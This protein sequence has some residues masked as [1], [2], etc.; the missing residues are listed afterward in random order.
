MQRSGS[1]A[2]V[3]VNE[4]DL[5]Q[6]AVA[7]STSIGVIVGRALRGE[8][9]GTT[10]IT[11]EKKQ[12]SQFGKP[13]AK[14]DYAIHSA[15][16]FMRHA[17]QLYFT[18]IAPESK[19]AG[20]TVK[21]G[22]VGGTGR[23]YNGSRSL[24]EGLEDPSVFD[25]AAEDLF[26]IVGS[27]QGKWAEEEIFVQIY[28]NT[29]V[30][31]NT[32][33]VDVYL[34]GIGNPVESFQVSLDMQMDGFGKQLNIE[35]HINKRSNYIKVYQ[36][37]ENVK[38]VEN[39]K[40]RFV[41]SFDAGGD[42]RFVGIRL[43]GGDDG[44]VP[45]K[46]EIM[47][48]WDL[49][50]DSEI[51]SINMLINAGYTDADIQ[52]HM[53]QLA[54]ERMDCMA[55]L[56]V[57]QIEQRTQDAINWRRNVLMVDSSYAA[58]YSPDVLVADKYN[59]V[60]LYLPPSGFVAAAYARTDK[61]W[62][63]WFAPAGW[64]RGDLEV[65]G[66]YQTY[67]Q[68]DRDALYDNQINAIRNIEGS[69]VKIWGADTL[70]IMASALSNI[71]VR[72]LMIFIEVALSKAAMYSVFD[73]NDPQ[74]WSKL[75]DLCRNFLKPI[76]EAEGLYWFEVK[77]DGQNNLPE[78]IANGDVILDVYLDPVLPAKRIHLSAVVNK[79]G[80]RVTGSVL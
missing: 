16:A 42:P 79:T 14:L 68:G 50:S 53:A 34:K 27:S 40:T 39:D 64:F 38:F 30:V 37:R 58:A 20:F 28:P 48:G 3:Y 13:N 31:D 43:I 49:Y 32:F 56:D 15:I 2:G 21:Y 52:R 44:R 6:R 7:P 36:N 45:T 46:G 18:R 9:G 8:V 24:T 59:D 25:F 10:L 33:W 11:S 75:E 65:I 23:W 78:T 63:T 71:N 26:L 17:D 62:A 51:I 70:Q 67:D 72:R 76:K 54:Y 4:I 29:V 61:E 77:C 55:I 66:V 5:S 35:H 22:E 69:G 57:P 47:D 80:S 74:L 19:Y 41:N 60:R 12:V 1:S 73:P